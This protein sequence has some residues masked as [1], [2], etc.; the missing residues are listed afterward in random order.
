MITWDKDIGGRAI[1]GI[2]PATVGDV[3]DLKKNIEAGGS[4]ENLSHPE[5]ITRRRP[6]EGTGAGPPIQE[7]MIERAPYKDGDRVLPGII[8]A[9]GIPQKLNPFVCAPLNIRPPPL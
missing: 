7:E 9:P 3:T 1:K 6:F 4:L 5:K 8:I 2:D